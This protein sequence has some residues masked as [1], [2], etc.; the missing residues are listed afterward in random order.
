MKEDKLIDV[1]EE[2]EMNV[3]Q[4][5]E[6]LLCLD[7][8]F[9]ESEFPEQGYQYVYWQIQAQ[10]KTLIKSMT[11]NQQEM[12]RGIKDYYKFRKENKICLD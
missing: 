11:L 12:Q 3:S 4:D 9:F 10:I 2:A 6:H 8:D 5:L 1:L 7:S